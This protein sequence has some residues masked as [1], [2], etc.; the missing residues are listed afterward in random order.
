MTKVKWHKAR[1]DKHGTIPT[2]SFSVESLKDRAEK[3][4]NHHIACDCREYQH[5]CMKHAL[6]EIMYYTSNEDGTVYRL[7]YNLAE[8]A[9]KP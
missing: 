6:E 8:K 2:A 5:Q 4:T 3:C 7:I 9:L 1:S